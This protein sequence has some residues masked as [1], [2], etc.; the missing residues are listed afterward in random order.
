MVILIAVTR[1]V[2]LNH[3]DASSQQSP[4]SFVEPKRCS[5]L[6]RRD[7]LDVAVTEA[8]SRS[9][10]MGDAMEITIRLLKDEY[11]CPICFWI[12]EKS[13]N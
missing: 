6:Q 3:P 7:D 4:N 12:S 2:R 10:G 1:Y 13:K 9:F 11:P 8:Y 5:S